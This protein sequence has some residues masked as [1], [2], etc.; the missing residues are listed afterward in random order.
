MVGWT[1]SASDVSVWPF[2]GYQQGERMAGT[3]V[4]ERKSKTAREGLR[5]SHISRG[6]NIVR[7]GFRRGCELKL[8]DAPNNAMPF[9]M[10]GGGALLAA[11]R[12]HTPGS[13]NGLLSEQHNSKWIYVRI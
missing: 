5:A 12:T 11:R 6:G 9:L 2:P 13:L 1:A 7:F 10:R 4:E 8:N 3:K